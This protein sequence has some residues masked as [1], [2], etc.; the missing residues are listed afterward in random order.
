MYSIIIEKGY[1]KVG[2]VIGATSIKMKGN[3]YYVASNGEWVVWDNEDLVPLGQLND[4]VFITTS[5]LPTPFQSRSTFPSATQCTQ[6]GENSTFGCPIAPGS[7]LE[8]GIA[9]GTC[10]SQIADDSFCDIQGWFPAE[11]D[12]ADGFVMQEVDQMTAFLKLNV[13]FPDFDIRRNNLPG[14]ELTPGLNLFTLEEML[15]AAGTS[16]QQVIPKGAVILATAN[17]NCDFDF[18]AS[19]CKPKWDFTRL[20]IRSNLSPGFN[21]RY[22]Q[23]YY[24]DQNGTRV[25]YRDLFKVWGTKFIFVNTGSA[26]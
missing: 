21:F 14:N 13:E 12:T 8:G 22:A 19:K 26:G 9:T 2:T 11:D 5:V 23:Y 18:A 15:Q 20:D 24:L 10:S 17:W 4:Q 6:Q 1:Q 25:Q 3:G 16:A 7:S